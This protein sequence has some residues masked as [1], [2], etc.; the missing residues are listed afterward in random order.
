MV[1]DKREETY[2]P[3]EALDF[4]AQFCTLHDNLQQS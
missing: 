3:R 1:A 2:I 4:L